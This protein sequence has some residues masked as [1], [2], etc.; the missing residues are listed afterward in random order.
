M[1]ILQFKLFINLQIVIHTVKDKSYNEDY[2]CVD[3]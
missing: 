2:V 3:V 1:S